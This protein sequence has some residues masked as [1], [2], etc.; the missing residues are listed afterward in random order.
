MDDELHP[1]VY[2]GGPYDGEEWS[3]RHE[4]VLA[5]VAVVVEQRKPSLADYQPAGG[6]LSADGGLLGRE[7]L[8][9]LAGRDDRGRLRWVRVRPS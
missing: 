7:V 4:L 2:V 6:P 5:R 8:Y 9:R 1:S 3:A